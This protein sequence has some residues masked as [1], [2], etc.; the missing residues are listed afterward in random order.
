MEISDY[1]SGSA[2]ALVRSF[3][4][5]KILYEDKRYSALLV[6]ASV[7]I[8]I[9]ARER[10]EQDIEAVWEWTRES[11]GIYADLLRGEGEDE[12][13]LQA[14][15]WGLDPDAIALQRE[16]AFLAETP[17]I[18]R[19]DSVVLG[20]RQHIAE[21]QWKGGGEG[22]ISLIDQTYRD[23]FP[24][25]DAQRSLGELWKNIGGIWKRNPSDSIC[26]LNTGRVN[27][28]A[29]EQGLAARCGEHGIDW[30]FAIPSQVSQSLSIG[31]N[32]VFLDSDTGKK[33]LDALYLDRLTE[34]M[35][36]AQIRDLM[37]AARRQQ[38]ILDPPPSY[39]YNQKVSCT[40]PFVER[41]RHRFSE[42]V[43][44]ALIPSVPMIAGQSADLTAI[45]EGVSHEKCDHLRQVRRW[46]DLLD[47]RRSLREQLVFKCASADKYHNHGGHGVWR[48]WGSKAV[49]ER[50]LASILQ[51]VEDL[52]EPWIV[53]PY[54]QSTVTLPL[55]H[56][57]RPEE[58]QQREVHARFGLYCANSE[59]GTQLLGGIATFSPFWKVAGKSAGTDN[60]G[61][62]TGS[63]FTDIRVENEDPSMYS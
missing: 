21:I 29:G 5:R 57:E 16:S 10:I 52:R 63:A 49:A 44:D 30:N 18:G 14:L 60:N 37:R 7:R 50:Q 55:S 58:M 48:L 27:W 38:I 2:S 20:A 33:R 17:R 41:Y 31:N 56:P 36:V 54:V 9:Q 47:L 26:V 43:R 40:L 6:P 51:R 28:G 32:G 25:Q 62:L 1:P 19:I 39:L 12:A 3:N 59:R 23:L 13:L 61:R 8:G 35:P 4:E 22:F 46:T 24:L 11:I 45:M 34:V 15:E 53:Q 42:R